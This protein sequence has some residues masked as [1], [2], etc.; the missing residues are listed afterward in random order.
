MLFQYK[1]INNIFP[2]FFMLRLQNPACILHLQGI[3]IHASYASS[4]QQPYVASVYHMGCHRNRWQHGYDLCMKK[5]NDVIHI[6]EL[7]C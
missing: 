7:V 1:I 6:C 2:I 5:K 4:A 3:L